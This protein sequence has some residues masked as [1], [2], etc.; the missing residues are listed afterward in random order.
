MPGQLEDKVMKIAAQY[1]G[2]DLLPYLGIKE[3]IRSPVPTEHI[4]LEVRRLEED[5]NFDLED[6]S[7]LHLEF[8]SDRITTEDL[9]R[10]REYEA[11]LGMVA[12]VPVRTVVIC[13]ANVRHPKTELRNGDSIYRIQ[14]ISLKHKNGDRILELLEKRQKKGKRLGKKRL[15]PMLLTPL[16]EGERPVVQRICSGVDL[17][18]SEESQI[19]TETRKKM[20]TI[21]YALAVRLLDEQGQRQVKERMGMTYLGELLVAD[22][23]EK[24][25]QKGRVLYLIGVV[26]KKWNRGCRAGEI[27]E[28]LEE[29]P[30]VIQRICDLLRR[31]GSGCSDEEICAQYLGERE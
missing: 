14:V 27:A 30:E 11:Y 15:F 26:R 5:F 2:E 1:F 18:R 28:F 21:L 31:N 10:F 22:G 8:E 7:I 19:D 25:L 6:G 16:M 3:K 4:H 9:R 13:T 12:Q 17:L 23:M 20:E 24:G 29:D